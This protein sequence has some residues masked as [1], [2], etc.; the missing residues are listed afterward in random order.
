MSQAATTPD[1]HAHRPPIAAARRHP[2]LNTGQIMPPRCCCCLVRTDRSTPC[3]RRPARHQPAHPHARVCPP[4]RPV[5]TTPSRPR[6]AAIIAGFL[7]CCGAESR[8]RSTL[9]PPRRPPAALAPPFSL[10]WPLFFGRLLPPSLPP[11]WAA[12][13]PHTQQHPRPQKL[14]TRK[15]QG[16]RRGRWGAWRGITHWLGTFY[17]QK[18]QGPYEIPLCRR[19]CYIP[20]LERRLLPPVLHVRLSCQKKLKSAPSHRPMGGAASSQFSAAPSS[21]VSERIGA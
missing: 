5:P 6:T 15:G 11:L 12:P 14:P 19:R 13:S 2:R 9:R 16:G 7:A 21:S 8:K 4:P 18:G 1:T 17:P 20:R 10:P 3:G